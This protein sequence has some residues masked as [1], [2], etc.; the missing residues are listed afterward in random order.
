MLA[1]AL[2]RVDASDPEQLFVVLSDHGFK[3]FRRGVNVNSWL[4]REGYLHLKEGAD[5][6]G[7]WFADVDW[8]RTKAFA[9]GLA[10][11]FLNVRGR[12]A[13]GCV[14]PAD[15]EALAAEIADGLTGLVDGDLGVAVTRAWAKSELFRGPY[16]DR[17]PDVVVGYAPGWRASW[18]GVRGIVDDVVFDDNTKAWS[19][20]H[21]ID[22]AQVPGVL[23]ANRP[24]GEGREELSITDLA[25][26]LLDLFGIE[27]PKWMDG[28]SL[29]PAPNAVQGGV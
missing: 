8:S 25:P 1:K 11:L 18:L 22:P 26:T 2:E 13:Q 27:A 12:E 21:C 10:G 17:S 15:A 14:D 7:E 16:A 3:T 4:R 6:S 19:G 5:E 28:T 29:A 24:L 20:D 9:L 23:F